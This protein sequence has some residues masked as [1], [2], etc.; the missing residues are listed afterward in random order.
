MTMQTISYKRG[1][2]HYTSVGDVTTIRAQNECS[3]SKQFSSE[4]AAKE[5]LNRYNGHKNWNQWNVS[6]YI[7][8]EYHLYQLALEC[9]RKGKTKA[10]AARMFKREL[11]DRGITHTA[12]GATYSVTAIQAAL[13]DM[14]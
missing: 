8:N 7:N 2:L 13:V 4:R 5:W 9:V 12:D 10:Q 6:L 1:Y 14:E 11:T 3:E